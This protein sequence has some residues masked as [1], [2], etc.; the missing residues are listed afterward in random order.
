MVNQAGPRIRFSVGITSSNLGVPSMQAVLSACLVA[1]VIG[2]CK[3]T[4]LVGCY[5]EPQGSRVLSGFS[6]QGND[7]TP[8]N[9]DICAQLCN[10]HKFPLA[11]VEDAHQCF[12]GNDVGTAKI[13]TGCDQPCS[14]TPTEKCGGFGKVLVYKFECE[15]PPTP[16]PLGP[17]NL[18]P[19]F[20]RP[21]CKPGVDLEKRIE[22]VMA[23][24]TAEDKMMTMA[25]HSISGKYSD[26]SSLVARGVSWWNEALHGLRLGCAN[27]DDK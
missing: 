18:C 26:G 16:I 1:S 20:S 10:D 12:C 7:G 25:E 27:H 22:M 13:G 2:S 11:G 14:A 17:Q 8:M 9:Y 24:M 6:Q 5:E 19:D 4:S 21:Y 23:H 3:M 15:G